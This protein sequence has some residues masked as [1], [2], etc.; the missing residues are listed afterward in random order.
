[1]NIAVLS[2]I[3]LKALAFDQINL[4]DT[5]NHNLKLI[6]TELAK[7]EKLKQQD[8]ITEEPTV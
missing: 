2:D 8:K 4:I 5:A 6:Q 1:M 7:R 3:E